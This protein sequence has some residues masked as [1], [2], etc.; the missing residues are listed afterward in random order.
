MSTYKDFQNILSAANK[1]TPVSKLPIKS[2]K[3]VS[4]VPFKGPLT[5][6]GL[7][8]MMRSNGA[9]NRKNALN[10]IPATPWSPPKDYNVGGWANKLQTEAANRRNSQNSVS[11]YQPA[12]PPPDPYEK[13]GG[14]EAFDNMKDSFGKQKSNIHSSALDSTKNFSIGLKNNILDYLDSVDSGQENID[15]MAINNELSRRGGRSG[16]L[17]MINRGVNSGGVML[18]GK[19]A[20]NSSAAEQLGRIYGDI[21]RREMTGVNNQFEMGQRDVN[22]AQTQLGR[23]VASGQRRF[24]GSVDQHINEVTT[25]ARNKLTALDADMINASMPERIAIEQE[26]NKIKTQLV[27][28]LKWVDD[29]LAKAEAVK[30]KD[31]KAVRSEASGLYS[32]GVAPENAFNFTTK[33]PT[34]KGKAPSQLPLYGVR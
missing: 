1:K 25:D 11:N 7:Q 9:T 12:A 33:A 8:D 22:I 15:N 3:P 24:E 21:G 18:A 26:K 17:E 27:K 34:A 13:W 19:N 2:S 16:V 28:D 23:Q 30:P 20:T 14:K 4:G 29:E 31:K 6:T 10:A 32:S 5:F